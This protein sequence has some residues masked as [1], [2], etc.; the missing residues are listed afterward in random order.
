MR[1]LKPHIHTL[2]RYLAVAQHKRKKG[3]AMK[4]VNAQ[5]RAME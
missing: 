5:V 2:R 4:M 1:N 3:A